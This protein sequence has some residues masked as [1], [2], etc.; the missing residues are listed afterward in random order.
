MLVTSMLVTDSLH[1]KR[2]QNNGCKYDAT[3]ILKNKTID[4]GFESS[5]SFQRIIHHVRS[6]NVVSVSIDFVLKSESCI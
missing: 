4:I 5:D 6:V 3:Q 1:S 2:R